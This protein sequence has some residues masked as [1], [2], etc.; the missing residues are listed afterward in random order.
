MTLGHGS[1][2]SLVV[3]H[4]AT[5]QPVNRSALSFAPYPASTTSW[6][7]TS[8]PPPTNSPSLGSGKQ[9]RPT[10]QLTQPYRKQPRAWLDVRSRSPYRGDV[11]WRHN[12]Q[13][14]G[15]VRFIL[16]S[17]ALASWLAASYK[18]VSS[19]AILPWLKQVS[20][21]VTLYVRREPARECLFHGFERLLRWRSHPR[22]ESFPLS[23][24][25]PS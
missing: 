12:R 25:R 1:R 21:H 24:R 23:I 2:N 22:C 5:D 14:P 19:P 7:D 9:T 13:N 17:L 15:A 10:H 20:N 8:T 11:R 18:P 16:S 3:T 4:R 6:Q